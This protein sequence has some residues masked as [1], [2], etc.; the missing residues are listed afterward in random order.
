MT[1][2]AKVYNLR[3][4][5]VYITFVVSFAIF[6]DLFLYAA[7]VPVFPF[8]LKDIVHV[9]DEDIQA[10]VAQLLAAFSAG[11]LVACPVAGY[12][13]DY[14]AARRSIYLVGLL[15]L[16]GSTIGLWKSTQLW[17]LF[18]SRIAQGIS[19]AIVWAIG[20]TFL[21][22]NVGP[23]HIGR[24]MG[25]T[26]TSA[27]F[28]VVLAPP[29]TGTIY[30]RAGYDGVFYLLF[31][32][33]GADI[34]FRLCMLDKP[35][36]A[37]YSAVID[38]VATEL[39]GEIVLEEAGSAQRQRKSAALFILLKYPRLYTALFFG[40]VNAYI[41]TSYD[42]ILPIRFKDIFDYDAF[43]TGIMFIALGVPAM[44]FGP[45]SGWWVDKSGPKA[46]AITAIATVVPALLLLIIPHGPVSTAQIAGTVI[47]LIVNGITSSALSTPGSVD[48]AKFLEQ[49]KEDRPVLLGTTGANGS[50][51]S[52]YALMYYL[53]S[54]C[55][56][57]ATSALIDN[58]NW[59]VGIIS[60]AIVAAMPFP[61]VIYFMGTKKEIRQV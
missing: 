46:V 10:R 13:A 39:A 29:I 33:V 15:C 59:T 9:P 2:F 3:S 7:F 27:T 12:L 28:A 42:T 18:V 41:L 11:A 45:L 16:L 24:A 17:A 4:S 52:F 8:S 23:A 50:A 5:N 26:S 31:A 38:E 35:N 54:I 32:I 47:I 58:V 25:F 60:I 36:S 53:G 56:P 40:F 14:F 21:A 6:T 51:Y 49:I 48:V 19:S 57:L 55:G 34:I 37:V 22:D 44:I 1:L 43:Q 30:S 20:L 61:L